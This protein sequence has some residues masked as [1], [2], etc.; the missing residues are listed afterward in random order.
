MPSFSRYEHSI[1][2]LA[3]LRKARVPL[4]EQVAG[5]FH[6]VSHT[7]FSHIADH[8][9]LPKDENHVHSYQ[10]T[11]H[12]EFLKKMKVDQ[13]VGRYNISIG[14]MNPDLT[15]YKA[16]ERPLPDICADRLQY[17]VHTGVILKKITQ[18][19][20]KSII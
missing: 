11:I 9:F 10:D 13:A 7:A 15:Q 19:Q 8:L 1:G 20:A 2:V 18:E 3:L 6:D 5:L 17:I 12:L 14:Q 4:E 16:V